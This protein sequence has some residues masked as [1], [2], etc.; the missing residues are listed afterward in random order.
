MDHYLPLYSMNDVMKVLRD[1]ECK[2]SEHLYSG[3]DVTI[4]ITFRASHALTRS[5]AGLK[6]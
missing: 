5:Q 6:K 1:E 3:S 2:Q 4:E